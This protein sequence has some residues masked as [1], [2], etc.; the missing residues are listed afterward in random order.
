TPHARYQSADFFAERLMMSRQRR[1]ADVIAVNEVQCYPVDK[2]SF[3]DVLRERPEI[4]EDISQVLAR[5]RAELEAAREDL[6]EEAKRARMRD[7]QG[8]LLQRIRNFFAL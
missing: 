2:D 7:H 8:D 3:H 5:R 6:T 1:P 4:A